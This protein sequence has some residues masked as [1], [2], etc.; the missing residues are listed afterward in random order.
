MLVAARLIASA[1]LLRTESRG[2]H[3]RIDFPDTTHWWKRPV[4]SSR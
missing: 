4:V 2:G 3:Y 1:A